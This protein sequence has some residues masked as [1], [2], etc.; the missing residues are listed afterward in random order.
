MVSGG[1]WVLS[2]SVTGTSLTIQDAVNGIDILANR[3]AKIAITV[4]LLNS[5]AGNQS[6][7]PFNNAAYYTFNRANGVSST[8]LT[9]SGNTTANMNVTEPLLTAVKTVS[10]V[11]PA[12]KPATAPAT[13]GDVL[14]YKLT[15]PNSSGPYAS[16][17]FDTNIVDT[18]PANVVLGPGPATAKINMAT[19]RVL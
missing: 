15:I 7:V 4:E 12:G 16:A 13:V 17:A 6:S 9:G 2:S 14:E 19:S 5:Y 1:A 8:K 11:S 10:F 3:Q 18:L